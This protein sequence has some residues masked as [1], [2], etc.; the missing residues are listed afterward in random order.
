M[1]ANHTRRRLLVEELE[2]RVAPGTLTGAPALNG[3]ANQPPGIPVLAA[4]LNNGQVLLY[5]TDA[6][7]PEMVDVKASDVFTRTNSFGDVTGVWIVGN[8][9]GLG[10]LVDSGAI[11]QPAQ[12]PNAPHTE[13]GFGAPVTITD[14][15]QPKNGPLQ[16]IS[17]I[18]SIGPVTQ[19][20]VRSD[21]IGWDIGELIVNGPTDGEEDAP[22][23]DSPS[24][25]GDPTDLDGD[26]QTTDPTAVY[27][28]SYMGSLRVN[29]EVYG[30]VV[31]SATD[32][33]GFASRTVS[34][35]SVHDANIVVPGSLAGLSVA[36]EF[37]DSTLL[38]TGNVGNFIDLGGPITSSSVTVTGNASSITTRTLMDDSSIT[39]LG[40]TTRINLSGGMADGS[41][42]NVNATN[43]LSVMNGIS[44]STISVHGNLGDLR[45]YG[46]MM[47]S[48]TVSVS[49]QLGIGSVYGPTS[50][51]GP[52][53]PSR[54]GPILLPGI[55]AGSTLTVGSLK[56]MLNVTGDLAGTVD[57]VGSA[58]GSNITVSGNLSGNLLAGLFGN[59]TVLGRFSGHIGDTGT[60]AGK[61]NTLLVTM[62]GGG[63][64]VTPAKAFQ[65]YFGYP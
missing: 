31:V 20:L 19:L 17:F 25:N 50:L 9:T 56:T 10:I 7:S 58:K 62:P 45:V 40:T 15:R 22:R 30:D 59:V 44:A 42:V 60:A 11:Q 3:I 29:G 43:S 47:S 64:V 54:N 23:L 35:G 63:G 52:G 55:E 21:I 34:F 48:S 36:G 26:G 38:V 14:V 16:D 39:V 33:F 1:K 41:S 4:V 53:S 5:D 12:P 28:G 6:D 8:P 65:Y 27:G 13:N 2:P 61:G 49:G 24:A 37:E 18:A 32:S 46:G 51:T 57:I